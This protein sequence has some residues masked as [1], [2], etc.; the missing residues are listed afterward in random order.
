MPEYLDVRKARQQ[1]PALGKKQVYFDNAGGSQVLGSVIQSITD[2]LANTNVQLGAT[3]PV[4]QASTTLY[5]KGCEA[6]AS[7]I[8]AA[9]DEVVL[10]P[11]TTQLFRN[12]SQSLG[13]LLSAGDELVI[14][15]LDHEANIASW[16]TLAEQKNLTIKW[17]STESA[18]PCHNPK[19]TP[20]N[21]KPLLSSKTKL[22]TCT[23]ASNI[24]GTIHDIRA[25]ADTVH[26]IPGAM[27]CVDAVAYAPHRKLDMKALDV[28]FYSF[29]WYKVYGPHIANLY[30]HRRTFDKLASLGHFFN[31]TATLENKLGL[32]AANYELV[33]AIPK[34]VEYLGGNNSGAFFKEVAEHEGELQDVLLSYLNSRDDVTVYGE[35]SPDPKLRVPTVSFSFKGKNSKEVVE[36][37]EANSDFGFRWGGFY[38]YRL[39][40]EILMPD[41]PQE[42]RDL[43]VIR[44]S[45]VHYNT[46]EEIREFVEVLNDT[47]KN[48]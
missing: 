21:L 6:A 12:L 42:A 15:K 2:Y 4:G 27:I 48:W 46:L 1:F 39:I 30:A 43:G 5:N 35:R 45:M 47:L 24:L 26:T 16:V 11:S 3:Y 14:S 28:D 13:P 36:R 23:H 7:Y 41:L 9:A 34:V 29:S 18:V 38:S 37:T 17:W 22:V 20:E 40:H 31:P 25:L 8:N 32:A 44:V 10:G 33:S 19:L